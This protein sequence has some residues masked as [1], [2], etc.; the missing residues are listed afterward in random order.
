MPRF[1]IPFL[2]ALAL[3]SPVFTSL[4]PPPNFSPAPSPAPALRQ[5]GTILRPIHPTDLEASFGIERRAGLNDMN[6]LKPENQSH[7]VWGASGGKFGAQLVWLE[8]F[9]HFLFFVS[10][11]RVSSGKMIDN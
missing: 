2:T 9:S 7:F 10:V 11:V 4:T 6:G 5:E 8:C 3:I 1:P